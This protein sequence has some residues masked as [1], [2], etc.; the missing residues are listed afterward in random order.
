MCQKE[1][2]KMFEMLINPKKAERHPWELFFIGIFYATI[3]ILLVNWVFAQ[4]AVLSK[5]AG[6][7]VVTF[8]VMFS[9]PFIY[10]TIKLEEKKISKA[11]STL[12]LLKEHKKAIYAFLF[13]FLGYVVA[14][15]FWYAI[16]PTTDSF[17]AQIE[18]YCIINRPG[19]FE[20]CVSQYAK[21]TS[22][23]TTGFLTAKDRLLLIFTNNMYVLVFTLLFSL[24]FGAGVIFILAWNASVIAA[25][26]GIFTN[27]EISS[28]FI[29]ISRFMIHGLPEIAS[30]FMVA[31]AGGLVSV[32]VIRHE[33]GTPNFWKVLHD[34]LNL[35]ILAVVVL[36][37]AALVEV[38]ITPIFFQ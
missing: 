11:I 35:I 34:S 10:Y 5:R 2:L 4:D 1:K 7:L 12:S 24:I 20:T 26:V 25:A 23:S 36:F 32:A 6:I 21:T 15:S 18:T 9:M 29:G 38:F 30:Y 16:L 28:F 27:S 8:T 17:Q 22:N 14:F 37:L 13:L 33:V 31:L 19:S 3:S